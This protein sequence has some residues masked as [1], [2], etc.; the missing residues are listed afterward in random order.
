[1]P[2]SHDWWD[3]GKSLTLWWAS[4]NSFKNNVCSFYFS[5]IIVFKVQTKN[6][7]N[8]TKHNSIL[9]GFVFC[10][11]NINICKVIFSISMH[12]YIY[13]LLF[14]VSIPTNTPDENRLP[15][16]ITSYRAL[17]IVTHLSDEKQ[18]LKLKWEETSTSG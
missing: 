15:E 1:M 4:E 17:M 3:G 6:V 12:I 9:C 5:Y 14:I 10:H 16:I 2:Q 11:L 7:H 13:L 18:A 8:N